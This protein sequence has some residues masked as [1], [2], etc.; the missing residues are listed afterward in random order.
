V[1]R[2][3]DREVSDGL[4]GY[5]HQGQPAE[6]HEAEQVF[7]LPRARL[8]EKIWAQEVASGCGPHHA[9]DTTASPPSPF[10][11]KYR[12]GFSPLPA[13]RDLPPEEYRQ[14]VAELIGEI[15][16]ARQN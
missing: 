16:D 14:K 2:A 9:L 7:G 4:P 3:E 15:L 6:V 10:A 12:V 5:H 8:T 13:L 1:L 11:T